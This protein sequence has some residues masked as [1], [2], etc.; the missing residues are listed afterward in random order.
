MASSWKIGHVFRAC[1]RKTSLLRRSVF[2]QPA[3]KRYLDL[4]LGAMKN[5]L[6]PK[7]SRSC[8][9]SRRRYSTSNVSSMGL[10]NFRYPGSRAEIE[11]GSQQPPPPTGGGKSRGLAGRGLML[12]YNYFYLIFILHSHQFKPNSYLKLIKKYI[13]SEGEQFQVNFSNKLFQANV[14]IVHSTRLDKRIIMLSK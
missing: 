2:Q 9:L 7:I 5:P 12:K 3:C 13:F 6:Y 14:P 1:S 4:P 11:R 10:W 8:E